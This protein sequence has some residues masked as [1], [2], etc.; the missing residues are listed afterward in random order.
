MFHLNRGQNS[1]TKES[2]CG[3]WQIRKTFVSL[4]V[5]METWHQQHNCCIPTG[6]VLWM[7]PT[8]QEC[9]ITTTQIPTS[10]S[11]WSCCCKP[12][13]QGL[14]YNSQLSYWATPDTESAF[15]Y[16]KITD[17]KSVWGVKGPIREKSPFRNQ[18]QSSS[19]LSH[20]NLQ[21]SFRKLHLLH[22]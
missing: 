14:S 6:L 16:L 5:V 22:S 13:Y 2:S 9:L 21:L 19:N 11:S 17:R 3:K 12:G 18:C 4:S 1:N 15:I 10:L 7:N 20:C 8:E